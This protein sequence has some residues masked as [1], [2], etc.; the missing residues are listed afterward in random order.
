MDIAVT[1]YEKMKANAKG[2]FTNPVLFTENGGHIS[3]KQRKEFDFIHRRKATFQ[4]YFKRFFNK[5]Y[6]NFA[7]LTLDYCDYI[8]RYENIQ[9]DYV[10]AL[11]K[12]KVL[13]PRALP[14]ANKTAGKKRDI[15][16][17]YTDEI[18]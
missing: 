7:S 14:V 2:N 10:K 12:A 15:S 17:Y 11:Q 16:I 3:P 9:K 4:E 8:I 6:D 1:V 5:P 13:T 18:K